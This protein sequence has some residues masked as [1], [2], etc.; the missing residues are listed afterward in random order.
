MP[1]EVGRQ[2]VGAERLVHLDEVL[3]RVLRGADAAGRLHADP[4]PVS[5]WTSR[6]ASSITSCD[7]Q[8]RGAGELAGRG[9]D[10]VGA[11]G[12][13]EQRRAAHVV[14]RA[15]LADLEDHLQVRVAAGLLHVHDL[16]EDLRVAAGE[17]RAAVDHH[18]DLV[19]AELRPRPRPR[20]A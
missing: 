18:V 16:V 3:D 9:L 6:I 14:V 7:R 5:S 17:E 15:E 20:A 1:V 4:R 8:R 11:G 13:R 19:G 10:E 12:H 2:P